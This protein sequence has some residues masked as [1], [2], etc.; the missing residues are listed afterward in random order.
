MLSRWCAV[1]RPI[2]CCCWRPAVP[3]A[4]AGC[5][6]ECRSRGWSVV[7][8]SA[9]VPAAADDDILLLDTLGE[10]FSCYGLA[11]VAF[12]G[13]SLHA[14]GGGHN[15]VEPAAWGVARSSPAPHTVNF[16]AIDNLLE[17]GGALLRVA[18]GAQLGRCL[19]RAARGTRPARAHGRGGTGC[20]GAPARRRRQRAD[21]DSARVASARL[22]RLRDPTPCPCRQ[23]LLAVGGG[24][25]SRKSIQADRYPRDSAAR[26][27]LS[28]ASC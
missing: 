24:G 27:A 22:S 11:T 18:D 16:E 21:E 4:A 12:V 15:C 1:R 23:A 2:A 6:P 28:A 26:P 25:G 19:S 20:S 8:R 10:L 17:E 13:G 7:R 14:A 3:S 9:G 5:R